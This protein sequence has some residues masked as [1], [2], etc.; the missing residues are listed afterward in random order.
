MITAA[1]PQFK[2]HRLKNPPPSPA[3][4]LN[5][6]AE[7]ARGD[8]LCF[9]VDGAHMLTPGAFYKALGARKALTN[10]VVILRYFYMG[11]GQQNE[12][13]LQGYNKAREASNRGELSAAWR[14]F[15]WATK[16]PRQ[17]HRYPWVAEHA[18]R[19]GF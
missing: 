7:H 18:C 12:T 3:Y 5:Y 14:E 9:M 15:P 19:L 17:A 2:Y 6:G 4:A 10:A 16:H 1:G 11:P 13:I 8:T